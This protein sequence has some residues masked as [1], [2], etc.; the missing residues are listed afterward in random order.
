MR[1]K[2]IYLAI[3]FTCLGLSLISSLP[4]VAQSPGARNHT[5][6]KTT[7]KQAQQ[8]DFPYNTVD[9]AAGTMQGQF[10]VQGWKTVLKNAISNFIDGMRAS[11]PQNA[12]K[13]PIAIRLTVNP[14]GTFSHTVNGQNDDYLYWFESALN[15]VKN[16]QPDLLHGLGQAQT[17]DFNYPENSQSGSTYYGNVDKAG[18]YPQPGY[19]P[20]YGSPSYVD[21]NSNQPVP[22]NPYKGH[23]GT[24]GYNPQNPTYGQPGPPQKPLQTGTGTNWHPPN[25]GGPTILRNGTVT[26]MANNQNTTYTIA[27]NEIAPHGYEGWARLQGNGP[28]NWAYG[29][30]HRNAQGNFFELTQVSYDNANQ[31]KPSNMSTIQKLPQGREY[32]KLGNTYQAAAGG[33][34]K[35]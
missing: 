17:L 29:K 22:Y 32:V 14:D 5:N 10:D 9:Q 12:N 1:L 26:I 18:Q 6:N 33:A 23:A 21:P 16:N 34:M 11:D 7:G 8:S 19:T 2:R 25:P 31:P 24:G 15:N 3:L 27:V 4:S 20:D 28:Y 30:V 13:N 35:F